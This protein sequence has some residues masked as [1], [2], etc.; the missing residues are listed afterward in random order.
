[1]RGLSGA[2]CGR[3]GYFWKGKVPAAQFFTSVPFGLT[4]DEINSWVNHGGGLELWREI[5]E[6]F[7]I[8]PIPAGN[9]GTQ[10]FGWFNKEINSVDDLKGLKMFILEPFAGTNAVKPIFCM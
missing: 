3:G 8:Y 1:M 6:P 10:M 9:T 2:C 5:Y 4:A 7:N